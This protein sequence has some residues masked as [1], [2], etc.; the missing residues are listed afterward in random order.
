MKFDPIMGRLGNLAKDKRGLR[1]EL[2]TAYDPKRPMGLVASSKLGN[3]IRLTLF[4]LYDDI[5][6][7]I[8]RLLQWLDLAI[9]QDEKA[10]DNHDF[11]RMTLHEAKALGTWF[12]DGL[13]APEIWD[14]ARRYLDAA[15]L[16]GQ[17]YGR[18]Q[19]STAY[20]DDYLALCYQAG[21]YG[22]GIAEYEKYHGVKALSLKK[23]LPPRKVAYAMCLHEARGQF[24]AEEL[25]QA[26]R[27]MLQAYLGETWIDYGQFLRAAKWLKIVYWHHDP[28]LTPQQTILK[29][30][31]HMPDVPRPEGM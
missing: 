1:F 12:R 11:H 23:T 31:E 15:M 26:G 27:N 3:V 29:A 16:Q 21:R 10:D 20:L 5:S 6:P 24:D 19:M 14:A 2:E 4:G 18:G 9:E 22:E 7:L 17:V 30:Y 28:T 13:N 25:Y 8:P